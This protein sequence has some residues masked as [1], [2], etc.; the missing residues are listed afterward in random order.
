[1]VV[2]KRNNFL[3]LRL[4]DIDMLYH[5]VICNKELYIHPDFID[6]TKGVEVVH[7]PI[8]NCDVIPINKTYLLIIPGYNIL[9]HLEFYYKIKNISGVY[10]RYFTSRKKNEILLLTPP[11]GKVTIEEENGRVTD[12][13]NYT[14]EIKWVYPEE[15]VCEK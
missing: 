11:M 15:I 2:T 7:F 1:M 3:G 4:A 6:I 5:K 8:H 14:G 13:N 12:V 9:H 10:E